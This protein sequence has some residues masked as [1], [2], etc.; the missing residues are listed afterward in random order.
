M[1]AFLV[2]KI[3]LDLH[4][5]IKLGILT[6]ALTSIPVQQFLF[7]HGYV[8]KIDTVKNVLKANLAPEDYNLIPMI[9]NLQNTELY[10][11]IVNVVK[12]R[13]RTDRAATKALGRIP[14]ER[15]DK[16]LSFLNNLGAVGYEA[17]GSVLKKNYPN[18]FAPYAFLADNYWAADKARREMRVDIQRDGYALIAPDRTSKQRIKA[19]NKILDELQIPTFWV[20]WADHVNTFGNVWLDVDKNLMGGIGPGKIKMLLPE[21]VVP[22]YDRYNEFIEFI[23]YD[24]QGKRILYPWD[25]LDHIMTYNARSFQLGS[26]CL[27]S[28]IVEIEADLQ[29]ALYNNT[30]MQKGGLIR[31][32]L[33][34]SAP[35]D[36]HIINEESYVDYASKMQLLIN[37][38]FSGVRGAGGLLAMFGIDNFFD[39]NKIGEIDGIYQKSSDRTAGRTA[40]LHGIP[41]ERLGIHNS[42]QYQNNAQV[43][44]S[45][46]LS[47]DN[48]Q[49]YLTTLVSNYINEKILK[50][51]LGIEDI[52]ISAAGEFGSVSKLAA[53]FGKFIAQM[54]CDSVTVNEFREKVLHW[55][56]LPTALGDKFVGELLNQKDV[57]SMTKAVGPAYIP[58]M[59]YGGQEFKKH[60]ANIV[61]NYY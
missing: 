27:T 7:T 40:L 36:G 17:A 11:D 32:V 14:A 57:P 4:K 49:Y 21:K 47:T 43:T 35:D 34:L 8:N 9:E 16:T 53:E 33:A 28:M 1:E 52:T 55:E 24:V 54:G 59:M 50:E 29:A 41:P 23:E 48:N 51:R 12:E 45:M 37:K 56:P 20:E 2:G 22:I 10:G 31:G 18:P 42:S 6:K 15:R 60:K 61:R 39:L 3:N 44:D 26:P 46:S 38:K 19:V 13:S 58:Q 5:A 30:V 25:K